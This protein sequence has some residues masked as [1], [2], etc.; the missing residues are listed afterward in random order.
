MHRVERLPLLA[1]SCELELE[2]NGP[3]I[4]LQNLHPRFKSGRRLQLQRSNPS[5]V[6]SLH[7]R[8]VVNCLES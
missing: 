5:F 4:A 8:R 6:Q 1:R 3:G 2:K 7:E